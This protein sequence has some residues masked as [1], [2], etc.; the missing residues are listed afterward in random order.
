MRLLIQIIVSAAAVLALGM[1]LGR[2]EE[3]VTLFA[4]GFSEPS[5]QWSPWSPRAEIS[6]VFERDERI[7]RD[8]AGSLRIASAG[9]A[10]AFG[11][12]KAMIPDVIPGETYRFEAW[13]RTE[14]VKNNLRSVVSRLLWMSADGRQARPPDFTAAVEQ[15]DGWNKV[16]YVA[17]SPSDAISVEIQLGFGFSEKGMVWWDDVSLTQVPTVEQRSIRVA[18]IHHRPEGMKSAAESVEK[19]AALIGRSADQNPDI[20][21]LPEGIT[22]VGNPLSYVDVA[23]SIPG[24]TT[25][26][27]GKLAAE[28]QCYIV[29]GI[30]ERVGKLVYNT[31]VLL[32]RKGNVAGTYRKTHLPREEWEAGISPGSS[33]PIFETDFG[34][35]GLMV[36]WDVQ[37]P[38]PARAMALQ[39]AELL[40]LPIWGGNEVLAKARAI[41]NHLFLVTSSYDMKSFVVDPTGKVLAQATEADPVAVAVIN[42]DHQFLQP[43]LGDMKHRTWKE[44]RP[45]IPV[46]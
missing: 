2:A 16:Q 23:E 4:T 15:I 45:D 28:H 32:D 44:R 30:Y 17:P 25:Q 38:E 9:N 36:C 7:G 40:L 13:Y 29:A 39:G 42:L 46:E 18:T 5:P 24:P 3:P 1:P 10:A 33:Y 43:W 19:F 11:S 6:P 37:F 8:S 41:E 34:T 22:T 26:V 27:L 14:Q 31:A 12:W 21:C 35:I 20:I